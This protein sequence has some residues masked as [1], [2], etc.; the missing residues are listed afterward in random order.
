MRKIIGILLTLISLI[1]GYELKKAVVV[2]AGGKSSS[3][4]YRLSSSVGQ[5]IVGKSASAGYNAYIG[6]WNRKFIKRG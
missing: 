2:T 4:S 3:S 6:F 1:Y 5:F